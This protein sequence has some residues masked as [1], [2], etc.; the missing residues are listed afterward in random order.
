MSRYQSFLALL[1]VGPLVSGCRSE[2]E[3]ALPATPILLTSTTGL[4]QDLSAIS[5][6]GRR[7][8]APSALMNAG[9]ADWAPDGRRITFER[10]V[11]G[12]SQIFT[13]SLDGSRLATQI[14]QCLA[15][16]YYPRWSPD[17]RVIAYWHNYPPTGAPAIA[18]SGVTMLVDT[19]GASPREIVP[20]RWRTSGHA[21]PPA[22]WAPD[23]RRFAFARPSGD[24]FVVSVDGGDAVQVP[25]NARVGDAAWA[26][27]GS[28]IA[29]YLVDGGIG[30][31]D[32]TGLTEAIRLDVTNNYRFPAWSPDSRRLVFSA[33][34]AGGSLDLFIMNVDGAERRQLTSTGGIHEYVA[35]WNPIQPR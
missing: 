27:D 28:T 29:A 35:R 3:P 9:A 13:G 33:D 21:G 14:T 23:S 5:I 8:V 7:V 1:A 12:R 31:F 16:C 10:I 22:S 6:D 17:G 19:T 2:S 4:R 18:D 25:T 24:L 26:S 15:N 34:G 20:T 11:E 32:P 30:L